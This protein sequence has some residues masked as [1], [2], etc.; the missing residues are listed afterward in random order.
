[1]KGFQADVRVLDTDG[2]AICCYWPNLGKE[3]QKKTANGRL[4]CNRKKFYEY[5]CTEKRFTYF[6]I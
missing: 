5:V 3:N 4:F 6:Q 1:M 2:R